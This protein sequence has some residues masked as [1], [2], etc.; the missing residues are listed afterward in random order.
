[1]NT[2]KISLIVP[3][4]NVEHDLSRCLDSIIH[5]TYSNFEL[6]LIDD[7]STD[8]SRAICT[9]YAKCDN[10]IR[11]F[12]KQN[13]GVSATRNI[14][15]QNAKG[16]WICFVDSDD[17]IELNY[18]QTFIDLLEKYDA[19]CY[20]TSCKV[21]SKGNCRS[22][23]LEEKI[24]SQHDINKAIIYLR[25]NCLFGVP[26]NKLFKTNIIRNNYLLFNENFS[27]YEDEIFVLQYL[28]YS[29]CICTSPKDTYIYYT[30][31]TNSLSR[32]YIEIYT[33]F[34]IMDIIYKLGMQFSKEQEYIH[35]LN[36]DY[37]RHL[38]ESVYRLYSKNA[39]FKR[40]QR[41]SIIRLIQENAKERRLIP[42]LSK[43]LKR[44][45]LYFFNTPF[46]LDING[47]ILFIYHKLKR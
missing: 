19:D 15:L 16:E 29:K 44:Y 4:Y 33:H 2:P 17:I 28:T 39:H 32:K 5:Q 35:H 7:G 14:G 31:N 23:I 26:W 8:K 37:T 6:L 9:T 41:L 24:F 13:T 25:Q 47:Q 22:I 36:N 3:V 20:I 43:N 10:R 30:N 46:L 1:M 11:V 34:K 42:V 12:H 27:S 40:K 21:S 45:H 18:L 38:T